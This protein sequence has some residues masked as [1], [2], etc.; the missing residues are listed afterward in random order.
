MELLL[1][2]KNE[3]LK[4]VKK[5]RAWLGPILIFI[6]IMVAFPLTVELTNNNLSDAFYPVL[7]ISILLV[8]MLAT[9][10]IFLEDY[11]DGTLELFFI[12]EKSLSQWVFLKI[13]M[14]WLFIGVPISLL[15]AFFNI[16]ANNDLASSLMLFPAL[17]IA[18]YIFLILFCF[19]NSLS[20]TKGSVLG[21]LITLP[22]TLP[23]LVVLGKLNTA[24]IFNISYFEFLI[25]LFGILSI[26]IFA[27]P[28]IISRI[29][30]T[31]L[32]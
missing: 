32:E 24:I 31:H 8:M 20:L 27:F 1:I 22:L 7:F 15:G 9:E 14:H 28:A 13:F 5:T 23:I 10:D 17:L 25:L 29:I 16:G 26:I 30:K 3:A 2:L 11:E 21:T 4:L 18:T 12:S 19:G 6:L